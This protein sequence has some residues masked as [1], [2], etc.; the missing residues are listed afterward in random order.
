MTF[1][2]PVLEDSVLIFPEVFVLCTGVCLHVTRLW[3][4]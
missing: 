3:Q 1:A 2:V 4:F